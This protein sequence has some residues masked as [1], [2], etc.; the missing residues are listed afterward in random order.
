[1]LQEVFKLIE[2]RK[3]IYGA[4]AVCQEALR[5]DPTCRDAEGLYI[6]LFQDVYGWLPPEYSQPTEPST[7]PRKTSKKPIYLSILIIGALALTY[8]YTKDRARSPLKTVSDYF[9]R[10]FTLLITWLYHNFVVK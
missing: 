2:G 7:P 10:T 8:L 3:D 5:L 1:M 9:S 4:L 6:E